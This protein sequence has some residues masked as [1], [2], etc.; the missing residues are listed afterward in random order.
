MLT[1]LQIYGEDEKIYGYND[2]VI[3]VG[4]ACL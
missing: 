4:L 2:L 1:S 3:D